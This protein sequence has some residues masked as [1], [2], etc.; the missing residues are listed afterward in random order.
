MSLPLE[1]IRVID[2]GQIFAAPYCTLQL[3]QMGAEIIKVEPPTTGDSLRRPDSSP[4]GANYSFLMLNANKK[5]VALNLKNPRGHEIMMRLLATADVMVENYLTGVMESLG[6]GYAELHQRFP[7]LI[8]ASGKGYGS[9]GPWARL[10]AMDSTVQASCGY[11]SVTG[12]PDRNGVK[13]PATV[14]DM[15]TGSHL[16][17]GIVAALFHRERTGRGQKVE[18]AMLDVC[19]LAMTGLIADTLQGRKTQR[20]GNR[21]R[22]ACPADVYPARDGEVLIFVLTESHWRTMAKLMGG[23]E[24]LTDLRFKDAPARLAIVDE[25]DRIVSAWTRT[26]RRDE[27]IALLIENGIPNAPVR[28]VEEVVA[29]PEVARRGMLLESDFPS[30]GPIRVIGSPVK[31]SEASDSP[32][33][34][35]HPP[36]LGQH[37]REVLASLGIDSE[38]FE[39]LRSDGVI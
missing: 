23:G 30:R 7:R 12:Y 29:D 4:G 31:L 16:V 35:M 6:L 17:S 10:G 2:C 39:R 5:S 22:Q 36:T 26:Y 28:T 3:A 19:I 20:L 34:R 15:G 11:M 8:Y 27:L 25:L 9:D 37:N 13:T 38:E 33:P 21:H 1:G 18:V 14:I 24:L 32:L